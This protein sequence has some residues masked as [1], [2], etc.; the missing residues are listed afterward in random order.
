MTLKFPPAHERGVALITVMLVF[1]IIAGIAFAMLDKI[2]IST[3]RTSYQIEQMQMYHYAIA[4]EELAKQ[5]LY[6]DILKS[7]ATTHPKQNW[8]LLR[9]GMP[10]EHGTLF[11]HI[12]DLEGRFNLNSLMPSSPESAVCFQNLFASLGIQVDARTITESLRADAISTKRFIPT[13]NAVPMLISSESLR[14]VP[15]LTSS[16]VERLLPYVDVRPTM[17]MT[18]N[19]NTAPALL[20]KA[21]IPDEHVYNEI[22]KQ[23]SGNGSLTEPRMRAIGGDTTKLEVRSTLF[24][25]SIT[26]FYN[27]QKLFL[28]STLRRIPHQ[29][30]TVELITIGRTLGNY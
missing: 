9:E 13:G 16:D 29:D 12:D 25:A 21:C 18:L 14:T 23:L 20:Q 17:D 28:K 27:E 2:R 8:A 19:I 1:A 3:V 11:L 22:Q 6:A 4:G 30:N 7:P 24:M 15:S 26:V 5:V 10:I